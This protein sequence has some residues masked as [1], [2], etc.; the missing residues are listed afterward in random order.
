MR[1]TIIYDNEVKQTGLTADHG[2][3]CLIEV[4]NTPDILFDTGRSGS[5]LLRNMKQLEIAPRDIGIVVISHSHGDHTG[6]LQNIVE[7]NADAEY[8]LPP[9]FSMGIAARKVTR[10][11]APLEIRPGVFSTGELA[12]V[13]Q[14]LAVGT[15]RGLVVVV[16]CSHSGV[17]HILDT[18]SELGEVYGIVGGFHG[19][20]DFERFTPLSLIC[21]CHCTQHK[22][23]LELVFPDSCLKCGAGVVIEL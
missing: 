14:S 1:I 5:I 21:P 6:G 23:E 7:A 11:K 2:F 16:G 20:D 18:A 10:V 22:S 17:G 9:S 8:Y 13:E 3:S 12:G 15:D 4:P 19:F